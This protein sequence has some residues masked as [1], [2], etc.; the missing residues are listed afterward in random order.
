MENSPSV[1]EKYSVKKF[2]TSL[3]ML[4]VHYPAD[5]IPSLPIS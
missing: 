1:A 4:K 3:A 5:K 2:S